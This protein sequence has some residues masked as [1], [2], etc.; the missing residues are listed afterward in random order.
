MQLVNDE[1]EV[2]WWLVWGFGAAGL[3]AFVLAG[4]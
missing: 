2:A 4:V 3:L 1:K